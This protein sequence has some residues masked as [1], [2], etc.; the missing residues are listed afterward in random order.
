MQFFTQIWYLMIFFAIFWH[1]STILLLPQGIKFVSIVHSIK[2]DATRLVE[3]VVEL[4]GLEQ[5]SIRQL[6]VSLKN[7]NREKTFSLTFTI[8]SIINWLVKKKGQYCDAVSRQY[9]QAWNLSQL[10]RVVGAAGLRGPGSNTPASLPRFWQISYS[11]L[12]QGGGC[13][14]PITLLLAPQDFKTF[15]RPQ[16]TLS[17][18]L[19]LFCSFFCWLRPQIF[20]AIESTIITVLHISE[21]KFKDTRTSLPE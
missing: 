9:L 16:L 5:K 14:M 13:I 11:Y 2:F 4:W 8:P 17:T 21:L 15:L 20:R 18:F 12:N 3:V 19:Q 10:D 7:R 1:F 6:L